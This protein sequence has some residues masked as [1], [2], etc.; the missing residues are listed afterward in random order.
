MKKKFLKDIFFIFTFGILFLKS[1]IFVGIQTHP[2]HTWVKFY[3]AFR[4]VF[5]F[6]PYRQFYYFSIILVLLSFS[7]I[8]KNRSKL[9]FYFG[10]N[11][12][13]SILFI[14]DIW[15]LRSY[16]SLTSVQLFTQASNLN[17]LSESILSLTNI[18]DLIFLIDL[19]FLLIFILLFKKIYIDIP[20][21]YILFSIIFTISISTTF[22]I[23][24]I[25]SWWYQYTNTPDMLDAIFI[26]DSN[27]TASNIS[28]I[29]YHFYDIYNYLKES[30]NK[31]LTQKEKDSINSWFLNHKEDNPPNEYTSIFKDKN[32][33]IIQVESLENFVINNK[34]NEQEICPNLNKLLTNSI[35]FDN[36]YEQINYGMSSDADFMTNTSIYPLRVGSTFFKYPYNIYTDSLP[37]L[38]SNKGYST[39]AFH[40]DN[41]AFWNWMPALTNIGFQ[42]C[43]DS[44]NYDTS[45]IIGFGI[46]DGSYFN[47]IFPMIT[48]LKQPFYSF[49]VTL[50]GH[51]PFNIPKDY[52]YLKID[53]TLDNSFLG[54]YLQCVNYED[55][56]IGLLIEKFKNE[57]MLNDTIFVIYGD[58]EGVHKFYKSDVEKQSNDLDWAKENNKKLPLII[59]NPEINPKT[60]STYGGQID[61]LPTLSYLFNLTDNYSMGKN[62]LNTTYDYILNNDGKTLGPN[63][64]KDYNS[65]FKIADLIIKGNYFK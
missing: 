22:L 63:P 47:Q 3:S 15:Y 19:L 40:P 55:K 64:Q 7:F 34:I 17:N 59:Y 4:Y 50:S 33:V 65:A 21:S 1:M 43:I 44:S 51:M 38:L 20:K 58:H 52:R 57:N 62:L 61:L 6:E 5:K 8:F 25:R 24:P 16:N 29:G 9:W 41:G 13:F 2:T 23:T 11:L 39:V 54:G 32:L 18:L 45:E 46:S 49:I 12:F 56:Q 48:K 60:I 35:Y 37:K 27:V 28:P 31:K 26:Y 53:E 36:Y 14:L 42:K 30:E 10:I